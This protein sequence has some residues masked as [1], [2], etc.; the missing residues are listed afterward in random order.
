MRIIYVLFISHFFYLSTEFEESNENEEV[1]NLSLEAPKKK[2][3]KG[4]RS[5]IKKM[6]IL[7]KTYKKIT[8]TISLALVGLLGVLG[9]KSLSKKSDPK[10][11][12]DPNNLLDPSGKPMDHHN[13]SNLNLFQP[14][15]HFLLEPLDLLQPNTPSVKNS[16][17]SENLSPKS[18]SKNP[19]DPN[20]LVDPSGKPMDRHNFSNLNLSQPFHRLST[21]LVENSKQSENLSPKSH[22]KKPIDTNN[23]SNL[24]LSQ[25][26]H[27]LSTPLVENSKQSENLSAKSDPLIKIRLVENSKQNNNLFKDS[28]KLKFYSNSQEEILLEESFQTPSKNE[29]KKRDLSQSVI[30]Q[31]S[32]QKNKALRSNK[33]QK[34]V[35]NFIL[36]SDAFKQEK[37][38]EV[39]I[40]NDNIKKYL[41][42]HDPSKRPIILKKLITEKTQQQIKDI[43][44]TKKEQ[45]I[46]LNQT[47]PQEMQLITDYQEKKTNTIFEILKLASSIF[48]FGD[49]STE[50]E[51]NNQKVHVELTSNGNLKTITYDVLKINIRFDEISASFLEIT[52]ESDLKNDE[53]LDLI[54]K[55]IPIKNIRL[56]ELFLYQEQTLSK[57]LEVMKKIQK[58]VES[59]RLKEKIL[60]NIQNLK[61]IKETLSNEKI[62]NFAMTKESSLRESL[63]QETQNNIKNVIVYLLTHSKKR[64]L[65]LDKFNYQDIYEIKLY[66]DESLWLQIGKDRE[67]FDSYINNDINISHQYIKDIIE[68]C[69]YNK[70]T[71]INDKTFYIYNISNLLHNIHENFEQANL[72]NKFIDYLCKFNDTLL[73]ED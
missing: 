49:F 5:S 31:D 38:T 52:Q 32:K 16:K 58:I 60:S 15:D 18:H 23:S 48:D 35:T 4:F 59:Q 24:N 22:L 73:S 55:I 41:L 62:K 10:I 69:V 37:F 26:F 14:L 9:Y 47:I 8:W 54:D 56:N 57:I 2:H 71:S 1:D 39:E 29:K 36:E 27:R 51:K 28:S 63:Y 33:M 42:S 6:I 66:Q 40:V 64:G 43:I 11:P 12:T 21:P 34:K 68:Q 70:T 30:Y 72:I 61:A 65:M 3:E 19:I 25:R 53:I 7:I 50:Y 67:S 46:I 45:N 20:H 44:S 17:Q 13:S